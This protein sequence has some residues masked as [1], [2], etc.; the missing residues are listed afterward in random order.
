[1]NICT[2][3]FSM[4]VIP[5]S[6]ALSSPCHADDDVHYLPWNSVPA[7]VRDAIAENTIGMLG[8]KLISSNTRQSYQGQELAKE[9]KISISDARAIALKAQPGQVTDQE[10]EKE[11]GGSG[12]RYSF[13]IKASDG[14]HEVGIDAVSGTV[15]E[16]SVEGDN[17]D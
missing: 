2:I 1:M 14:V 9:A 4:V 15:L 6:V 12:L 16:N 13:D 7:A 5:L 3:S 11:K 10:L 17:P 8:L